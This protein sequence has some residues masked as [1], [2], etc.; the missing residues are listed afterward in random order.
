MKTLVVIL[1]TALRAT[2]VTLVVTGIAYPLVA[3][4]LA[5]AIFPGRAN[6]SI[7]RDERGREVGSE[8][9][10]QAFSNAAYFQPR[11]SAAG[12]K[13]Y[14]ATASTGSNFGTTS[15]KLRDRAAQ[16]VARLEKDNPGAPGPIPAELV[17]ASA[18]GL[19]PHLSPEAALWQVPRVAKARGVAPDRVRTLVMDRIEGR[20]LGFLGEPRVNVLMLNLALDRQFGAPAGGA[21]H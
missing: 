14:D 5:Q 13:G 3:T 19:D 18:S 2:L 7:V 17:T 20:D 6:G 21:L 15:A 4:G 8:L 16:D 11:P 10:G 1:A 9:I 12:D